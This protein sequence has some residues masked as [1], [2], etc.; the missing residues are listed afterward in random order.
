MFSLDLKM[1]I[2][3]DSIDNLGKEF[4][5]KIQ[6]AVK[7]FQEMVSFKI[8]C[9]LEGNEEVEDKN[10]EVHLSLK[11]KDLEYSINSNKEENK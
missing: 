7:D 11:F 10:G 6:Q 9:N 3:Q 8:N 1:K 5:E 4:S 2:D